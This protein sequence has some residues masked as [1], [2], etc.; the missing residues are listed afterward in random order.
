MLD[1]WIVLFGGL[2]IGVG[3]G[4]WFGVWSSHRQLTQLQNVGLARQDRELEKLALTNEEKRDYRQY[5]SKSNGKGG[6]YERAHAAVY[7]VDA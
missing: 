5:R 3:L 2:G 1:T 6:S 7:D 4:F